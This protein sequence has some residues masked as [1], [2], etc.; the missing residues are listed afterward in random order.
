MDKKAMKK[1]GTFE[2]NKIEPIHNWYSYVEGYSSCLITD[3]LDLLKEYN[4]KSIYDPFGGTGTTPLVASQ[5]GIN[6]YYSETNPFMLNVIDTK[7]NSVI[8]ISKSKIGTKLLKDFLEEIKHKK[9]EI[10]NNIKWD[11]FEKYFENDRLSII[12]QIKESITNVKDIDA[13]KIL[14]LALS[15]IVVQSSKTIRRGDLRYATDKE[16][17]KKNKD[18]VVDLFVNKLENIINDIDCYGKD[19]RCKST[20]LSPDARDIVG[21]NIFDCIIT[22]PPYLNG[23]NY[24]RNTKL[25]LKLNDFLNDESDMPQFHSKGIIA[26]INNVSS[27]NENF[28]PLDFVKPYIEKLEPVVYDKRIVKMIIG[29]FNDMNDV[30]KKLSI[31]LKDNGIFI[32]D[33]GDSQFAGVHIPTH[34]IL[35]TICENNGFVKYDETI[36]R[37]RRSKN[38]MVLSQRILR[39][40]LNKT[41]NYKTNNQK[42]TKRLDG[43]LTLDLL[44]DK[45]SSEIGNFYIKAKK[46]INK[47]PYKFEPYSGRNWG[48]AWHSLCSYHGKLKPA[49]AYFLVKDFTKKGDVILDPLSGVGTIPFEACLQGRIG[50]GNDLS[51]MAYIVSKAKL[52]KANYNDVNIELKKLS[53]YIE[54]NKNT[55]IINQKVNENKDFG[56]NKTL[57][58]YFHEDTFREI[59]CAREYFLNKVHDM[60]SEDAVIFS[61]FMHILH[62]NRPYAL[63]RTSHPLT[64]Y[65]PK[66]EFIYKNVISHIKDKLEASYK[67]DDFKDYIKGKAIYGDYNN[68]QGYDSKVDYIICSPPFADSMRFY[69]QNW[70]RLWLCGWNKDDFKNAEQVFLD[71]KQQKDF[72]IYDS[73]FHMCSRVLKEDGKVI[74]HLGKTPKID[75][76]E[77]LEKYS[78]KYFDTVYIGAENVANIEKHGIKD[79][80]NTIEHEFMFLIKK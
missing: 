15:S 43:Q 4:I 27:R 46:F 59:V 76:A 60:S 17:Q 32:M 2:L 51:E 39:F 79:K 1:A 44:N 53:D 77:E 33:I 61:A 65:A 47:M 13:K 42:S 3:E 29:Y 57:K 74:L 21:E 56:Y 23:T 64:P 12:L 36:L 58:E 14:M 34:E 31:S 30:I 25:E 62:G 35:T 52:E 48:H 50:I 72:S 10:R 38:N 5:R 19:V 80:G 49:I 67:I 7:I 40:K 9:F 18:D 20:L 41:N 8:N 54:K 66:G 22:S 37:E 11:G 24:I 16:L 73:F 63:S 71:S 45:H 55:D 70:M 69:M 6:S 75:M 78:S 68:I 26:G 28:I